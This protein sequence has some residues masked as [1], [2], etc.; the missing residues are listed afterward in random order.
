[1]LDLIGRP[2]RC[3]DG[4]TRRSFLKAG[5][6]G[7]AGLSLADL[8]RAEAR[9][10]AKPED[11]S[12]ILVWL[13]GGPTPEGYQVPSLSLPAGLAVAPAD[14]RRALLKAFRTARRAVDASGRMDGLDRFRQEAYSMLPGPAA[15]AAFDLSKESPRL[16]D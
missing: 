13:D 5:Y 8:L 6:L 9:A 15:R 4:V 11:L 2:F 12:V 10:A 3:C 14:V 1:M 7:L 16:R